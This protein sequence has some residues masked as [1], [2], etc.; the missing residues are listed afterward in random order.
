MVD[1]ENRIVTS[2]YSANRIKPVNGGNHHLE[3][4][5][6]KKRFQKDKKSNAIEKE[7]SDGI[8]TAND[9]G[10]DSIDIIND[11]QGKI[12]NITV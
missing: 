1:F 11:T 3:K 6:L 4:R 9:D 8:L 2:T 7:V 10:K 12:I 5:Q